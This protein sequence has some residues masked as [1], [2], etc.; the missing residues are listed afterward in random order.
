[1]LRV[2]RA[3]L[4]T[5]A[6]LGLLLLGLEAWSRLAPDSQVGRSLTWLRSPP[7]GA[8]APQLVGMVIADRFDLIGPDGERVTGKSFPGK[9]QLIYFGYT[10]CPTV[11]PAMLRTIAAALHD[12][13][14]LAN[15]VVP[16]FITVDPARD[17][18]P[19]LAR[20]TKSFDPAMIGLTGPPASIR[21]AE[22]A[23]RVT[24]RI[25]P[26]PG[27][28]SYLIDHSTLIYLM[29]PKGHLRALFDRQLTSAGLALRLRQAIT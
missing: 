2:Y 25:V 13:G 18:P 10:N 14:P 15:R 1:M 17:T 5:F 28:N 7:D 8:L 24:A 23:F 26:R 16:L 12:A 4:A 19:V 22:K 27:T 11:C 3:T 6:L 9:W 21:A 20:Y 29:D